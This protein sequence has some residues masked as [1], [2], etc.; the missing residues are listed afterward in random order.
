MKLAQ[1]ITLGKPLLADGATGTMLQSMGLPVGEAPERWTLERPDNI[2]RLATLYVAAGADILY[3]NTFGASRVHLQR[4]GLEDKIVALNQTAVKLARE[5][6]QTVAGERTVY[7]VGSIGPTGEM[8]EPFGDLSPDAARAAFAEQARLLA[9]AG[10]DGLVC[11]TFTDLNEALLALGAARKAAPQLPV[12]A[13]M[14]FDESGR[15]MMGVTPADAVTKLSDAGAAV[16]GANCSVGP[17]VVE[18]VI[19]AMGAA[20][21]AVRLLAKPNAGLPQMIAGK[22]V[23]LLDPAALAE[24]AKRM[25]LRGV[26]V[27]GG[28]CGTTPDHI[29]A[30]RQALNQ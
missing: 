9:E 7:V 29:R 11:E 13:S 5:A 8:L 16:V 3:T 12:L 2:R 25:K 24:F 10:V 30:M 21:P 6:A 26:A 4:L 17:A 15:T 27:L 20:R 28:C 19:H 23:Y 18:K 14:A 22:T 1:A